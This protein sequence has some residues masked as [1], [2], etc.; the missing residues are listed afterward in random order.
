MT[1]EEEQALRQEWFN[2]AWAGLKSQGFER[3]VNSND[4][5]YYRGTEGRRC[6]I[7]WLMPDENYRPEFEGNAATA[8]IISACGINPTDSNMGWL[9]N[10]QSMHDGYHT[11]EEMVVALR[12][13]AEQSGLVVPS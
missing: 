12:R 8:D 2:K 1:H 5:C 10:L 3:S 11:P 6:A 4:T 7:G 13:F 9:C